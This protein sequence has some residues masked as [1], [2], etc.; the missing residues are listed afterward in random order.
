MIVYRMLNVFFIFALGLL[1]I[2]ISS[3]AQFFENKDFFED[4]D[5]DYNQIFQQGLSA[6]GKSLNL[7][8]KKIGDEGV[9]ALVLYA[10]LKKVT[11]MD[12]RYNKISEKGA[13]LLADSKVLRKIKKLDLRHNYFLDAGAIALA[14]SNA[15]PQL[16]KLNLSFNEIRDQGALAFA[17]SS[18]FPKL[19]KL[20]LAGNFLADETKQTLKKDLGHLK[21]LKL[22]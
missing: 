20:D 14:Q 12:L 22:Y 3:K 13:K 7:S 8:G 11:K 17:R 9:K 16:E 21:S 19:K 2:P 5:I 15:L 1:V 18:K 4:S 10:P 6:N